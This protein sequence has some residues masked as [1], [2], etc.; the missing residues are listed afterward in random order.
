VQTSKPEKP[1]PKEKP[2]SQVLKPGAPVEKESGPKTPKV[3]R[4]SEEFKKRR[5]EFKKVY[6]AMNNGIRNFFQAM[7]KDN[8]DIDHV[9]DVMDYKEGGDRAY[10]KEYISQ[11]QKVF[12]KFLNDPNN[13]MAHSLLASKNEPKTLAHPLHHSST[14]KLNGH[15]EV[16]SKK[17]LSKELGKDP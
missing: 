7:A 17:L 4:D 3:N 9:L 10:K 14:I 13:R 8:L 1:Q 16:L 6:K 5:D 2:N 12:I 11:I 15:S